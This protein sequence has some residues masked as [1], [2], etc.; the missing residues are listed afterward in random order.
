MSVVAR[1]Q[2]GARH[3]LG[4]TSCRNVNV[5]DTNQMTTWNERMTPRLVKAPKNTYIVT[6]WHFKSPHTGKT[7]TCVGY[8]VETGLELRLQY[9]D[10]DVI[11]TE[12][13]RGR[14]ARN[15]MN[16]YAAHLREDM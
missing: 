3:P 13:F 15:V 12:L 16:V 6:Y 14:D 8:E 11:S 2:H 7:A 1:V 9:N 5:T 10:D 4:P